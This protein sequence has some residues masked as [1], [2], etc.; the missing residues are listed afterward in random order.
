M[1]SA[2]IT[3]NPAP[4]ESFVTIRF[5]P[6]KKIRGVST[7]LGFFSFCNLLFTMDPLLLN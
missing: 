4:K 1:A 3:G 6:R 2:T 5:K 7:P